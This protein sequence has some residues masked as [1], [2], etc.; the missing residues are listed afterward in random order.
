MNF[1][2]AC[3]LEKALGGS[4]D[5][6]SEVVNSRADLAIDPNPPPPPPPPAPALDVVLLLDISDE[7]VARRAIN[8]TGML[9]R[10][11]INAVYLC[12]SNYHL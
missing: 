5:V 12:A 2:Q 3:L 8:Q 7:C 10:L 6:G 1:T 4:V 9:D 11:P